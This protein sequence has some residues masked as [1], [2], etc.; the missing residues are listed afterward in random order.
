MTAKEKYDIKLEIKEALIVLE[1]LDDNIKSLQNKCK[2]LLKKL[3]P[4]E[5]E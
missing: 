3:N 4:G 5:S 2:L 1:I